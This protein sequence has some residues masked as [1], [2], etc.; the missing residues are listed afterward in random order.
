MK[1]SSTFSLSVSCFVRSYNSAAGSNKYYKRDQGKNCPCFHF[2]NRPG[3]VFKWVNENSRLKLPCKFWEEFFN[4]KLQW[5]GGQVIRI[6]LERRKGP[7]F[8][9]IIES[10]RADK[11]WAYK[12]SLLLLLW[13]SIIFCKVSIRNP[14]TGI[15]KLSLLN[16]GIPY[17]FAHPGRH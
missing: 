4:E 10:K 1:R 12:R 5:P 2:H 6:A 16:P 14:S 17:Y 7:V 15:K 13:R 3:L 8:P 11:R 9:C